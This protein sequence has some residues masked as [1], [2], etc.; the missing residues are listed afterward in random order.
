MLLGRFLWMELEGGGWLE[1]GSCGLTTPLWPP[2]DGGGVQCMDTGELHDDA[3]C[4]F[5]DRVTVTQER[6]VAE[7]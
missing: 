1:L 7:T 4:K 5:E 2:E 6:G 3:T